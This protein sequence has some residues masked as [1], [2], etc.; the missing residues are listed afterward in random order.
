MCMAFEESCSN[1]L[2]VFDEWPVDSTGA[3]DFGLCVADGGIAVAH[4]SVR[5]DHEPAPG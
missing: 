4:A 5:S 1:R 2:L 3:K